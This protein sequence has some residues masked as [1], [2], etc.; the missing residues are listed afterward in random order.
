MVFF[1]SDLIS[2]N[3]FSILAKSSKGNHFIHYE[4]DVALIKLKKAF[5]NMS[6]ICLTKRLTENVLT[7]AKLFSPGIS[8]IYIVAKRLKIW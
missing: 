7:S 8:T 5:E 4:H 1:V 6:P 2:H 3:Q